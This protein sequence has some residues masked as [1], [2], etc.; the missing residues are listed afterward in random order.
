MRAPDS[1]PS[2]AALEQFRGLETD[3]SERE[4]AR[5]A[6]ERLRG[7]AQAAQAE[8][9]VPAPCPEPAQK[10]AEAPPA[11]DPG[12]SP[13]LIGAASVAVVSAIVG[14]VFGAKALS[15]DVSDTATSASLSATAL[16]ERAHRAEREALVADVAFSLALASSATFAGVWLLSPTE[17]RTR[18]AIITLRG[19]F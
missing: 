13:V 15:D 2:L 8:P 16:R 7:A 11:R 3:T 18:A 12:P 17:P 4:R 6:I 5:L 10:P 19:N 9:A 14:V 1:P